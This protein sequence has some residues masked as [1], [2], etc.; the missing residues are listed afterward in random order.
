L[1]MV[2]PKEGDESASSKPALPGTQCH[3]ATIPPRGCGCMTITIALAEIISNSSILSTGLPRPCVSRK[4]ESS[5]RWARV[6]N[7][8][9]CRTCGFRGH[10]DLVSSVSMHALAYGRQVEFPRSFTYLGL[11]KPGG[12]EG[13]TRLNVVSV[14]RRV[15]CVSWI[16]S[17]RRQATLLMLPRNLSAEHG[18][19]SVTSLLPDALE[20]FN[21][22]H[23][24]I[25]VS[26]ECLLI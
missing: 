7:P 3:R 18:G 13:Q 14:S 1:K 5:C 17:L 15:N 26:L 24:F 11:A 19:G 21:K 20:I 16:R 25:L 22:R 9:A 8:W 10:R 4:D 6:A 2:S 23:K 12:V